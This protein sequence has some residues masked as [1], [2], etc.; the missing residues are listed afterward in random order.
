MIFHGAGG[1]QT[2][3]RFPIMAVDAGDNLHI[4]FSDRHNIYLVSWPA[5]IR[6][7]PRAGRSLSP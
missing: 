5:R 3:N 7:S 1:L 6:P 2:S 4:V